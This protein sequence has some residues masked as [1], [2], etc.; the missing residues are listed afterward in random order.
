[1]FVKSINDSKPVLILASQVESPITE[2]VGVMSG[3]VD[4]DI[5]ETKLTFSL[6]LLY[7]EG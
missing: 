4:L 7:Q 5:V 3:I 2:Y 6:G 1:M